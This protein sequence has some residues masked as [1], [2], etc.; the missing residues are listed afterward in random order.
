ML[1][2][3]K[4]KN[5]KEVLPNLVVKE[6]GVTQSITEQD[7]VDLLYPQEEISSSEQIIE[8]FALETAA[9]S[10]I[11][12]RKY[13][14]DA[15]YVSAPTNEQS[16]YG[17]LCDGM[18][19]MDSGELAS[20]EIVK[21][22]AQILSDIDESTEISQHLLKS[23]HLANDIMHQ[24]F[25]SQGKEAGTTLVCAYIKGDKLYWVSV[26]DSRIYLIRNGEIARLTKDHNYALQLQKQVEIGQI[27]QNAADTNPQ[28]E[29]LVSYLG[30][31]TL[32]MID[33]SYS[34]LLLEKNDV[35]LLCS[36][37][38]TKSLNDDSILNILKEP[39]TLKESVHR[40]VISAV[41]AGFNA[42]DNT[43]AI[44]MRYNVNN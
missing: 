21:H 39:L 7:I 26:G 43:T 27:S 29:A 40:L 31:P 30:A 23:T 44:L 11:G 34:P 2:I 32:E 4:R 14:Q 6:D 22:Y 41:D 9:T 20:G 12:T 33:L 18:G 35:I 28:K 42:Q 36:D 3:F 15:F 8:T 16:A 38:V 24:I 10:H 13:Q 37:G 25:V 5:K 19:G 17:V 1:K